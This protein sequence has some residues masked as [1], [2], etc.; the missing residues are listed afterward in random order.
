MAEVVSTI[1]P[2][3]AIVLLGWQARRKGFMPPEF[4]G[5]AM[6]FRKSGIMISE[7][8]AVN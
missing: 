7:L 5:P 2:I 4:L 1:V 6:R 8:E 3:F